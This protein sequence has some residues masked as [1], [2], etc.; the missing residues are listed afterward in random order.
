MKKE[1]LIKFID[2]EIGYD[3]GGG[4]DCPHC[5]KNIRPHRYWIDHNGSLSGNINAFLGFKSGSW[6][7]NNTEGMIYR[8]IEDFDGV[9]GKSKTDS[10]KLGEII[11]NLF[12]N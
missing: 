9:T 1:D 5:G 2:K 3:C 10:K 6:R 7:D 11:W 12:Y 4:E 8:E